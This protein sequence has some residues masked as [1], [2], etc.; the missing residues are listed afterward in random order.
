MSKSIKEHIEFELAN[1]RRISH[2]IHKALGGYLT[3]FAELSPELR[4]GI[5]DPEGMFQEGVYSVG[6]I[7]YGLGSE[8]LED[9]HVM[10]PA[11]TERFTFRPNNL[12]A[13]VPDVLIQGR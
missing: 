7:N 2:A 3:D 10:D 4:F 1:T 12:N 13:I 8:R 9:M 11:T 5:M 6:Q